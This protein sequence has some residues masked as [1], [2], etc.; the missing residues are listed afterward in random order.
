MTN[1]K[2]LRVGHIDSD[3]DGTGTLAGDRSPLNW[4]ENFGSAGGLTTAHHAPL[5][6]P[7]MAG[8]AAI[9]L[10]LVPIH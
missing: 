10:P 5:C 8:T 6:F 4:V 7:G 1:A 9:A 3:E 2:L